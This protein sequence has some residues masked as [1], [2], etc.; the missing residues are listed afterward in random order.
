MKIVS[1]MRYPV[2]SMMGEELNAC[3]IT[4]HGVH[5]D[6][7]YGVMDE[8]TRKLA[9]AKNPKK[10]PTMFQHRAQY[11][12]PVSKKE[13]LPPVQI[14]LPTGEIVRSDDR[15]VDE[16]LTNSFKRQVTL[17]SPSTKEVQFEGYVPEEL[18][19]L[20]DHGTVFTRTSPQETFFDI[21]NIHLVSTNTIESLQK[22]AL[23]SRIEPRRFRPNIIVQCSTNNPFPEEQWIGKTITIGDQVR[24][25]VLQPTKRCVMTTLAQGDLPHDINVL[26]TIVRENSGN[27]GIY[28]EVIQP[29]PVTIHDDIVVE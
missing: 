27:V 7:M 22:L 6:R 19:E 18:K 16:V 20:D 25:K 26:K 12:Q 9:N 2:K 14:T 29:G 3:D 13:S 28:A 5:G 24:L 11:V 15:D 1:L 8:E 17:Q 10:W 21:A 4:Y 23:D